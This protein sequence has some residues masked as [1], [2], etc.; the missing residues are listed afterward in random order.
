MM[1]IRRD[2][3]WWYWLMTIPLLMVGLSGWS[4]GFAA[5]MVFCAI[6]VIH[7]AW[8]ESSGSSASLGKG[9]SRRAWGGG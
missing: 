1:R 6:Q 3:G 5:A 7:F 4:W 8:R 2:I 9:A